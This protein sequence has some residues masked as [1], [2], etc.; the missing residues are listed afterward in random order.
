ML[1]AAALLHYVLPQIV[2]SLPV[3]RI[4]YVGASRAQHECLSELI[5][6][7]HEVYVLE[8][9]HKNYEY[10]R[11]FPGIK[12]ATCGDVRDAIAIYL[13]RFD[14]V[15]WWFGPE[16]IA[17]D[18]LH[19]TLKSLEDL[20]DLVILGCPWGKCPQG[21]VNGNR[22]EQHLSTLYPLD[23]N[24]W[25]YYTALIGMEDKPPQ[26]SIVAWKGVLT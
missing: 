6:V 4:L 12:Y 20:S 18:D 21:V 25:G 11:S 19:D 5:A 17:F 14:I 1:S 9:E 7:G 8:I 10:M 3:R 23:L 26:S 16:H 13:H 22:H 2:T 24:L 15:M